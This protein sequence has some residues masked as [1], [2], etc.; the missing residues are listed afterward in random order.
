MRLVSS[1]GS[2]VLYNTWSGLQ[3]RAGPSVLDTEGYESRLT[4]PPAPGRAGRPGRNPRG[5]ADTQPGILEDVETQE[6]G[7]AALQTARR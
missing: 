5:E 4:S 1:P 3:V 2:P 7:N 6:R